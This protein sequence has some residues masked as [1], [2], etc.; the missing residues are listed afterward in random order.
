MGTSWNAITWSQFGAAIDM[1]ERALVACPEELWGDRSEPQEFWY[2][3]YHCL[4]WLDFYLTGE[5]QGFAPPAPFTL[6]EFDPAGIIPDRVYAKQELLDYLHF[7]R[8]KCQATIE[9]MSDEQ[10]QR[11]Y[12]FGWGQVSFAEL[13]LYNMRHVQEHA[14]QLSLLLGLKYDFEPGWVAKAKNK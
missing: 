1:L 11:M 8:S 12:R 3:T 5:E 10:A 6:D 13:L 2:V 7:G 14:A 4:F 9:A